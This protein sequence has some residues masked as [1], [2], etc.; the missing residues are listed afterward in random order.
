MFRSTVNCSTR[1]LKWVFSVRKNIA[2]V[3]PVRR[4]TMQRSQNAHCPTMT[5]NALGIS[6]HTS[7]SSRLT[8][9]SWKYG[10]EM[11]ISTRMRSNGSTPSTICM[12]FFPALTTSKP[13]R[14][15][16]S[17][18]T[19]SSNAIR[20][21]PRTKEPTHTTYESICPCSL[22]HRWIIRTNVLTVLLTG[23][24]SSRRSYG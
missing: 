19:G 21:L 16:S 12:V 10:W 20:S 24:S 6:I 1:W 4:S 15:R 23:R 17:T 9:I 14:L 8:G 13:P 22:M 18:T 5:S 11:T 3:L 7:V 2:F